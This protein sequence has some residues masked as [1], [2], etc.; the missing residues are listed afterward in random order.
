MEGL[1]SKKSMKLCLPLGSQSSQDTDLLRTQS[2]VSCFVKQM[3]ATVHIPGN[4]LLK[5]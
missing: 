5:V 2:K 1:K 4:W 3:Q